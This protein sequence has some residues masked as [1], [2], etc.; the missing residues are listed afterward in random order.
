[1]R[2]SSPTI[3]FTDSDESLKSNGWIERFDFSPTT[4]NTLVINPLCI[5]VAGKTFENDAGLMPPIRFTTG[6]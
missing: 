1:M 4:S 5:S 6:A 2:I 3:T